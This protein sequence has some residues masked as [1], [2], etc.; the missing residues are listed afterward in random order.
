MIAQTAK[1]I[2]NTMKTTVFLFIYVSPKTFQPILGVIKYLS[3]CNVAK[4]NSLA[5]IVKVGVGLVKKGTVAA[6]LLGVGLGVGLLVGAASASTTPSLYMHIKQDDV[7]GSV[8]TRGSVQQVYGAVLAANRTGRGIGLEPEC[9]ASDWSGYMSYFQECRG[10]RDIPVM[11][12]AFTSDDNLQLTPSQLQALIEVCNV[13]VLRFHEVL[14][15]Y[16]PFPVSYCQS[17]LA[18]AKSMK[19]PVFWNEWDVRLYPALANIIEGYEDMVIVS[20]GTNN[21]TIEPQQGYQYLQQ[22]KR[23]G[24]SVQAWYWYNRNGMVSG[25]ENNMPPSLMRE[26]TSE[27]FAV[28]CEVV[29]YEPYSYFFNNTAAKPVLAQVLNGKF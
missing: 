9:V 17:L 25:S 10:R 5:A 11:L 21:S 14:S 24:A 3:V 23:R 15:Y 13:K 20:F 16:Q 7:Y 6:V 2:E 26:F 27:A 22:F 8:V 1:A 28:G 12:N 18:F 4:F 19:L 29:Q